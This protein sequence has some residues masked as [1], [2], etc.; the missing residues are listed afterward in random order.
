MK[1]REAIAWVMSR[2][3]EHHSDLLT[4][5]Q[6]INQ[7]MATILQGTTDKPKISYQC[8]DVLQKLAENCA[9]VSDK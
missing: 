5:A 2:I 6:I 9:P 4:N 7:F 3:S 8:C 1:V